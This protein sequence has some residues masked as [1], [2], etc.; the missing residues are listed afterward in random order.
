MSIAKENAVPVLDF[1]LF[2]KSATDRE[3]LVQ[4]VSTACENSGFMIIRNHGVSER[5]IDEC[6]QKSIAFFDSPLENRM[7]ATSDELA[8]PYCYHGIEAESLAKSLG[9][10]TPPDLKE[11]FNVGPLDTPCA[12]V[13]QDMRPEF[14]AFV[15][16]RNIWPQQPAGFQNALESYFKHIRVLSDQVMEV[17]ALALRLPHDYFAD[18][19]SRPMSAMR[20]INY[21]AL[22]KPPLAGQLRAGAHTDYGTLTLLLQQNSRSGLQ[23]FS[24]GQWQDVPAIPGTFVVNIGD[25]MARWTN[26]RWTSTLHR[27]VNPPMVSA[28][29]SRRQSLVFFHTPN[30]ETG[31]ECIPT[32][33]AES[34]KPRYEPVL[35]GPHLAGKFIST[36]E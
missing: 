7:T 9:D 21:P 13:D 17:F 19:F 31:I 33:L 12:V 1:G 34:E 36:V 20:V 14:S 29:P 26:D 8:H 4:Q 23:V 11:T 16:A 18:R 25:L 15:N 2:T 5:V 30:W 3:L 28:V 27:V 35:A 6:W 22:E 32:C 10:A 24:G